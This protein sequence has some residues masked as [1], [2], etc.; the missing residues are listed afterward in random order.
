MNKVIKPRFKIVNKE[1]TIHY[2]L[3]DTSIELY[4]STNDE[5]PFEFR[6][7]DTEMDTHTMS[8]TIQCSDLNDIVSIIENFLD[9]FTK[10]KE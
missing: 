8:T 10:L 6:I 7:L 3:E 9:E 4:G 5:T 2:N 1:I